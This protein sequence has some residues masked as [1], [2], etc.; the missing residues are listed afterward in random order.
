MHWHCMATFYKTTLHNNND[1]LHVVGASLFPL[2]LINLCR[3]GSHIVEF[4]IA[5][6]L[7]VYFVSQLVSDKYNLLFFCFLTCLNQ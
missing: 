2:L 6:S 1:I 4:H 3:V 5:L 7:F